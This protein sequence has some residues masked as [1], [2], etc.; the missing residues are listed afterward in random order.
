[1]A[2]LG[3]GAV[4]SGAWYVGGNLVSDV[5]F[6][7]AQDRVDATRAQIANVQDMSAV[8]KAVGK[9]VAPSVVSIDVTKTV[10]AANLPRFRGQDLRRLFPDLDGDGQ[11]DIPEGFDFSAPQQ[12]REEQGTGSGVIVETDGKTAYIVT[13]NH[14]AGNASEMVVTLSDGREIRD[15]KLVGA[16]P[17]TDLAVVKIEADRIIPAKW[18]DSDTLEKGDVILAFGSPFGYVGSMTHGI[19]SSLH[20]QAGI[21]RGQFAYENFIQVDAPINPGNSG[22]PLVNLKGEIVGINTAIAT[23]SGGFQGVGFTIPSNQVKHVYSAIKDKGRVVR[24]WL[25]VEITD[26]SKDPKLA[27]SLGYTEKDGV[28]VMGIMRRTPAFGKLQRGDIITSM[29][30]KPVATMQDLRNRIAML[31]PLTEVKFTVLR[32]GKS[33]DLTIALGEQP[34]DLSTV[35]AAPNAPGNNADSATTPASLGLTRIAPASPEL[36][37]RFSLDEGVDGVV[38]LNVRPGSAASNV[39]IRPGDM[40]TQVEDKQIHGIDDLTNALAGKDVAKGIKVYI[41]N[42]E[43]SR[44]YFVKD[45]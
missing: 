36:T 37:Q 12:P 23:E 33:T 4:L 22:G 3:L 13:N 9:A 43:G 16:D 17:K 20:R 5:Q 42:R 40:I 8:F 39:N 28:M 27:E 29:D 32:N 18:G 14:V 30:G 31:S 11:P 21:I 38:V 44:L 2:G 41:T 25:G 26:V 15:A 1:M 35:A 45:Q 19:V 10:R 34:D 24:G 7:R 6:A